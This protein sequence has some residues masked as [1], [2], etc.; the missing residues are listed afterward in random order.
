MQ[1]QILVSFLF[2]CQ[3]YGNAV[4]IAIVLIIKGRADEYKKGAYDPEVRVIV[5]V[6]S[7]NG[8]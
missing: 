2:V 8:Y 1:P 4:S 7:A 3:G 6:P 5:A